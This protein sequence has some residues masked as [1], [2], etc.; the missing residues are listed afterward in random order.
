M[1]TWLPPA[2]QAAYTAYEIEAR[3]DAGAPR[4]HRAPGSA[5]RADWP[6]SPIPSR[7]HV[8]LRVRVAADDRWSPWS[9]TL[10]VRSA[11]WGEEDWAGRWI[12]PPDRDADAVDRGA[13]ELSTSFEIAE[14]PVRADLFATA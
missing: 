6:W 3:W 7:T 4:R 1:L 12:S 2:G 14:L 5:P 11:L 9:D 8:D 10:T 13:W